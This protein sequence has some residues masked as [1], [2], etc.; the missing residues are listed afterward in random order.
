MEIFNRM[1]LRTQ[2]GDGVQYSV[3]SMTNVNKSARYMREVKKKKVGPVDSDGSWYR[4]VS[5]LVS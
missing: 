4:K 3:S 2:H 5:D 1:G